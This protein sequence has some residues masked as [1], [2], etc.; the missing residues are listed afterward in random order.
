MAGHVAVKTPHVRGWGGVVKQHNLNSVHPLASPV[1]SLLKLQNCGFLKIC[2]I[3]EK[4]GKWD[5][6]MR[7]LCLGT[8]GKIEL[9]SL[10]VGLRQWPV[11]WG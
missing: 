7:L 1:L 5:L 2:F 4:S 11:Q 8:E 3:F 6:K 9:D 10:G